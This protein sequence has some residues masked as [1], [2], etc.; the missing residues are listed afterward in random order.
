M[1]LLFSLS[2][3]SGLIFVCCTSVGTGVPGT[4]DAT[5]NINKH[6]KMSLVKA[7]EIALTDFG[8][9][10]SLFVCTGAWSIREEF[11]GG[12][13]LCFSSRTQNMRYV[14]IVDNGSVAS[15]TEGSPKGGCFKLCPH[16]PC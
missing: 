4:V 16:C 9:N 2:A 10:T 14:R 8:T 3:L 5:V 13:E 7:H 15:N 12:W 11:R 6:P 1:K